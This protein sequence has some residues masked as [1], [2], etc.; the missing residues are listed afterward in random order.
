M[1]FVATRAA[2]IVTSFRSVTDGTCAL[3]DKHPPGGHQAIPPVAT[4]G[5]YPLEGPTRR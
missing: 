4:G 1:F 2:R 3:N 5:G